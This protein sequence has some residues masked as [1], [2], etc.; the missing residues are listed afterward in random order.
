MS[1]FKK[2]VQS[3]EEA[4]ITRSRTYTVVVPFTDMDNKIHYNSGDEY[5]GTDVERLLK[6]SWIKR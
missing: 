6:K 3:D 1:K 2:E 4:Q 5:T